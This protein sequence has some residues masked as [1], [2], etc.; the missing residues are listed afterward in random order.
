MKFDELFEKLEQNNPNGTN[1]RILELIVS[2]YIE[3]DISF[4]FSHRNADI[5]KYLT[6]EEIEEIS[7]RYYGEK[8]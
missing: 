6:N 2:E 8:N 3:E 1:R 4:S 5:E 7:N